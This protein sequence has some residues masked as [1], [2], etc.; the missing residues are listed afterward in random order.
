M[1]HPLDGSIL[2]WGESMSDH[3]TDG[4][5]HGVSS[6]VA[7]STRCSMQGACTK[8]VSLHRPFVFSF[9]LA[10]LGTDDSKSVMG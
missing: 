4:M 10:H 3:V 2:R 6:V 9:R 1:Y 7:H 5:V 8:D